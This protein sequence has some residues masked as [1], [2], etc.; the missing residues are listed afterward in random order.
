MLLVIKMA[1]VKACTHMSVFLSLMKGPHDDELTWPLR[2]RFKVKLFNQINDSEHHSE[3]AEYNDNTPD[4]C[5]NKIL[6]ADRAPG[7]R[8]YRF[9][10][11][12]ALDPQGYSNMSVFER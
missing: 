1:M 3:I 5:G 8:H 9:I 12:K 2:G 6:V 11:N 10:S 7:R 4:K